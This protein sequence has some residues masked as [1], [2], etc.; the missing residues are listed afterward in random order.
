MSPLT[1]HLRSRLVTP[2]RLRHHLL[3]QCVGPHTVTATLQGKSTLH[4]GAHQE[5]ISK[6]A[7]I[8]T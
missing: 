2:H 5:C 3:C 7:Q 8:F 4:V 6:I 1:S